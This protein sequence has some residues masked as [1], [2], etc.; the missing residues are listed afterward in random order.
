VARS[1]YA[2]G[3]YLVDRLRALG[4]RHL[5]SVSGPC[6]AEWLRHYVEATPSIQRFAT[7][8]AANAGYAADGYARLNGIGAVC[9][10]RSV[11]T[12]PLLS[13]IAGAFTERVPVVVVTG[14]PSTAGEISCER[15][16][17]VS[18]GHSRRVF[19]DVTATAVS[20]TTPGEAPTQIDCA[21]QTCLRT[22]RPVYLEPC[23]D[24]LHHPCAPPDAPLSIPTPDAHPPTEALDALETYLT[25]AAS[26]VVWG[27]IE[28][29]RYGLEREFATLLRALDAPYV[30]SLLG[31]G[32][33]AEDHAQFA[34]ILAP[35]GTP[36]SVQSLV[37]DADYVLGLGVDPNAEPPPQPVRRAGAATLVGAS[38]TAP[39]ATE[40]GT[41][42]RLP[43]GA[44]LQTLL[45]DLAQSSPPAPQ[46]GLSPGGMAY[47]IPET[48]SSGIATASRNWR[49]A[50]P[51]SLRSSRE[52]GM[53]YVTSRSSISEDYE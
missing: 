12:F 51:R 7:A 4:V 49:C 13:P 29:Q 15:E 34:G 31:K 21:L 26:I 24:V 46:N 39:S 38:G 53:T 30:T 10:P 18:N 40:V 17:A 11:G 14:A 50:A 52:D 35:E 19:E 1:S 2:V 16:R 27:G 9:V 33:L 23:A 8:T 28:L 6:C 48:A 36:P 37:A 32:L 41:R 3:Q 44:A 5:F 22:R 43:S 42:H 25:R 47:N 45:T 20:I